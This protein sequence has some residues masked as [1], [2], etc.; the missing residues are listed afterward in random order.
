MEWSVVNL[1]VGM[2]GLAVA[3]VNVDSAAAAAAV[4]GGGGGGRDTRG[5]LGEC[6]CVAGVSTIQTG[7][8]VPD[9]T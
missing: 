9:A 3:A 6:V 1:V 5:L 8:N 7:R 2:S 4:V